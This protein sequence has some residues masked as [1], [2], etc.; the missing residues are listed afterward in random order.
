MHGAKGS[1]YNDMTKQ[2][3]YKQFAQGTE[4]L[5]NV[6][7]TRISRRHSEVVARKERKKEVTVIFDT[8]GTFWQEWL[9]CFLFL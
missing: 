2:R 7:I 3:R 8:V 1:I 5:K 6:N 4:N 9:I